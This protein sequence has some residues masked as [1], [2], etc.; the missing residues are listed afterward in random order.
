MARPGLMPIATAVA[1]TVAAGLSIAAEHA[2]SSPA[3]ALALSAPQ[4]TGDAGGDRKAADDAAESQA[5]GTAAAA[6]P[7][8]VGSRALTGSEEEGSR[9][10]PART[11][12][13]RAS[14]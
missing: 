10:S 11:P 7:P 14:E 9:I 2:G 6:P 1:L 3:A 13:D 12:A 8:G 5:K 4:G